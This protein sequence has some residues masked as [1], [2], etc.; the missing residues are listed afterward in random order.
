MVC[1]GPGSSFIL[2]V[3][4]FHMLADAESIVW[5]L[6]S[7]AEEYLSKSRKTRLPDLTLR[8]YPSAP[9]PCF[10][11][12]F[13]ACLRRLAGIP[14]MAWLMRRCFR[15]PLKNHNDF[16]NSFIFFFGAWRTRNSVTEG[17]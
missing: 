1:A 17:R 11:N 12:F 6:R 10:R 14:A 2:A 7:C 13:G 9:K 4:Y 3:T 15:A 5:L 8:I 16:K